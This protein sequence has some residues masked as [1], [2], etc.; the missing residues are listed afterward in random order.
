MQRYIYLTLKY[1]ISGGNKVNYQLESKSV[2]TIEECKET[3]RVIDFHLED[4]CIIFIKYFDCVFFFIIF[5][6]YFNVC[7]FQKQTKKNDKG[8]TQ[9]FLTAANSQK[10]IIHNHAYL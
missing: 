6:H 7:V 1:N 10:I 9:F 3:T 4:E 8:A 5:S 2:I